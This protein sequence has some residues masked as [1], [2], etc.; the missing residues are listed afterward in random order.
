MSHK[1]EL[2]FTS[3]RQLQQLNGE[4]LQFSVMGSSMWPMI[5]PHDKVIFEPSKAYF[6][7]DILLF[8]DGERLILHRLVKLG[9]DRRFIT[10]GDNQRH[11]D[12]PVID[13]QIL[14]H[15]VTII[16]S[17]KT[18]PIRRMRQRLLWPILQLSWLITTIKRRTI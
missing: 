14:G 3:L 5:Q 2:I 10:K 4:A 7:G 13:K 17:G 15:A 12:T 6:R 8:E 18:I 9:K 11:F 16:R 1:R